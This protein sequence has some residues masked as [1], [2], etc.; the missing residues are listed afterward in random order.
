MKKWQKADLMSIL[1]S[2]CEL[3]NKFSNRLY[4]VRVK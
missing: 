3:N 4:H 1:S 2:V